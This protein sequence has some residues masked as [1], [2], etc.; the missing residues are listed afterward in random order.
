MMDNARSRFPLT[1]A[2]SDIYFD[3][4]RHPEDPTYNIGGFIRLGV[5][6][7]ERL[8]AA[9][10]A[11]V[12]AHDAFGL[13]IHADVTGVSQSVSDERDLALPLWDLSGEPDPE[14]AAAAFM[15]TRF[16]RMFEIHDSPLYTAFLL[17]LSGR[18]LRYCVIAH[19]LMIDGWG[20]ANL[21]REL[22]RHYRGAETG[23]TLSWRTVSDDDH[24]YLDGPRR[25][26]DRDYWARR[27]ETLPESILPA[28]HRVVDDPRRA[29]P[30]RR[31]TWAM[32]VD[33]YARL[34]AVAQR[35]GVG[36]PQLLLGAFALCAA[37]LGDQDTLLIGLPVHNRRGHA[38]KQAIGVFTGMMPL[39]IALPMDARF[40][41][42]LRT[43]ADRQRGDYRHQRYPI[44]LLGRDLGLAGTG[45]S[46]F[47]VSYNHL[48]LDG[49][50]EIEGQVAE[51]YYL[52][53]GYSQT[54]LALTVWEYGQAQPVEFHFDHNLAC[55]D[56]A[57]AQWFLRR[58]RHL[59]DRI[60]SESDPVLGELELLPPEEAARIAHFA[61]GAPVETL[62]EF[63]HQWFETHARRTP[64]AIA[65]ADM[66]S[67]VRYCAL[68]RLANRL[69]R[70]LAAAGIRPDDRVA[71]CIGREWTWLLGVLGTLKAGAAYLPLDPAQ[72]DAR[73][74]DMLA[75]ARPACCLATPSTAARL[76]TLVDVPVIVLDAEVLDVVD[77]TPADD[78]DP[79]PSALGLR[80]DHL[81]YVIFTSGSSG[82]PKGVMLAHAGLA[83]LA[84]GLQDHYGLGPDD[85]V[86]QFS[87]IGFDAATWD[88]V[89]AFAAGASLHVC[90]D[91]TR[92]SGDQLGD[93]LQ[94][95]GITHA[96]IP[97]AALAHVDPA[98]ATALRSLIVGGEACDPA[99]VATWASRV[100]LFNA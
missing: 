98:R 12:T 10:A 28:R 65:V 100:R 50:F 56:A 8:Q 38:Q 2:Q 60:A 52:T 44:G 64:D 68:N 53:H 69:A 24:Q 67:A 34:A 40:G 58:Y 32:P 99:V 6:D 43:I 93:Y 61:T 51:I 23:A 25:A 75:D 95:Q 84:A 66:R 18:E 14:A 59:L 90:D 3:Q 92:R 55:M 74:A 5:V 76:K 26:V 78:I 71:L 97:P 47:D 77:A 4:Q 86:L 39:S 62:P 46:L 37:H 48:K 33:D 87:S 35:H 57:D 94:A 19:H 9:H 42:W 13:R 27:I 72:P 91:D 31:E 63:A 41:D 22:A 81:A 29:S 80:P 45:R 70:T 17:K 7:V 96:L 82:R 73:I 30:S 36:L 16:Q 1:L 83:Q 54:P 85:R 20:F 88:W 79:E 21:A 89:R 11:M 15:D 49:H